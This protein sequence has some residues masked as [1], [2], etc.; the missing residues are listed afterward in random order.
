MM[1]G[2]AGGLRPPA[3]VG[4]WVQ[5]RRAWDGARWH[6]GDAQLSLGL[7][8]V[9]AVTVGSL[10]ESWERTEDLRAV[11]H[12]VDLETSHV[13]EAGPRRGVQVASLLLV[14]D[15]PPAAPFWET[16]LEALVPAIDT[17]LDVLEPWLSGS[18]NHSTP[19]TTRNAMEGPE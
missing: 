10:T 8:Q 7:P 16:N 18:H 11:A 17:L 15:E 1:I 5:V 12:V 6:R 19:Q 3:R 2:L 13:L 14:S 4:T 9:D